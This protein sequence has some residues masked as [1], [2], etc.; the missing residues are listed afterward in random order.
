[1]EAAP[2]EIRRQAEVEQRRLAQQPQSLAGLQAPAR[3]GA[4]QDG[5]NPRRR[6]AGGAHLTVGRPVPELRIDPPLARARLRRF[7]QGCAS[8][9]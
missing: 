2:D 7:T 8:P 5:V 3:G 6:A 1:M 4:L 9:A